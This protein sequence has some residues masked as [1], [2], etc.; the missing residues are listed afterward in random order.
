MDSK[1]LPALIII[2]IHG[3]IKVNLE[4]VNHGLPMHFVTAGLLN[5]SPIVIL[6]LPARL[7]PE[8]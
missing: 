8:A 2:S 3:S 4:N 1:S 7:Q 5:L 6:S